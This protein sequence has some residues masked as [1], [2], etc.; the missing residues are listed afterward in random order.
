MVN[1]LVCS[2]CDGGTS[3]DGN[4]GSGGT[5]GSTANV[6]AEIVRGKV[7]DGRVVVGVMADVLVRGTLDTVRGK[8]LKDVVTVGN[9]SEDRA[10]KSDCCEGLHDDCGR[11]RR[12]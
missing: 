10:K 3:S 5:V 8:V 12:V 4:R 9:F 11:M 7:G 6:T 2:E 1:G